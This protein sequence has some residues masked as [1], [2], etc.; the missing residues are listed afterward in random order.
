MFSWATKIIYHLLLLIY[1]YITSAY[2]NDLKAIISIPE[3]IAG[4]LGK[5]AQK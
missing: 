4:K 3:C 1:F 5:V 2:L